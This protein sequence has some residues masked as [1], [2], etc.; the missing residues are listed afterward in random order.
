[1]FY[2]IGLG[3]ADVK[4]VTVKG[5]EIIRKCNRVY[6]EAYTSVLSCGQAAL[7]SKKAW[8]LIIPHCLTIHVP[9]Q[10]EF[11]GRELIIAD[12]EMVESF[13]D[14][15]LDRADVEDVALLVIGDPFGATTHTD[16][17][18]RAKEKNIPYQVVHNASIINAVGCCGL[19]LYNYG[20][21]V[22][23]PFW[24]ETWQPDSFYEKIKKNRRNGLHTLCL[25]DIRVK[26][27]TLES[28]MKKKREYEP[29][30][31]MSCAIAAEQLVKIVEA[32]LPESIDEFDLSKETLSIG[33][34]RVG[35]E[36][37]KIVACS[38]E[39]MQS[40]DLGTPLHSMVIPG[41]D[42]HPLEKEYVDQFLV[43]NE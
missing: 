15:I 42:L 16:F 18:L 19:Q 26:E 30:R 8:F 5:L 39:E 27:P 36:T 14:T 41:S 9:F 6:L 35:H 31:F 34:A 7:V 32:L 22:S 3:L 21:I 28:L 20:E 2:I 4:D 12:R 24:T 10:E 38:L 17:I 25:L 1:M 43:G 29:P 33:V 37:Q 11:Y 13:S 40:M 23:I